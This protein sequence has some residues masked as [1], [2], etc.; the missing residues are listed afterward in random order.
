ML[1]Q[2]ID[3]SPSAYAYPLLIK[4][5]LH[6]PLTQRRPTRKSSIAATT[7]R[8]TARWASALAGWPMGWVHSASRAA[9]RWP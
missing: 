5:L 1:D 7:A 3:T 2:V 4:H 9:L 6:T 8:P